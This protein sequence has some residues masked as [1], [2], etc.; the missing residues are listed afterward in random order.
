M[1][2][3]NV[4]FSY[5]APNQRGE[6]NLENYTQAS[7]S[8]T[9][10]DR[11]WV[12]IDA[13]TGQLEPRDAL[14]VETDGETFNPVPTEIKVEVDPT[15]DP[16]V[17]TLA[18]TDFDGDAP[19]RSWQ[20]PDGRVHIDFDPLPPHEAYR[21]EGVVYDIASKTWSYTWDRNTIT[22]DQVKEIRNAQLGWSDSRVMEDVPESVKAPWEAYRQEL[23]DIPTV[24]A[25]HEA[26]KVIMPD[27][28]EG[29]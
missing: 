12:F 4:N 22:W 25:G 13:E 2:T 18:I 24:W 3:I 7:W 16:L 27:I 26:W 20:L 21:C 15:I 6:P 28:P 8:Y 14:T 23:R 9:G 11:I 19:T 10:P 29:N 1:T 5:K 17:A